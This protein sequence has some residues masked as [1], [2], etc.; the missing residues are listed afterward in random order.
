MFREFHETGT[1]TRS[2]NTIFL[3]FILKK[4]GVEDLRDF[5][6]ISLMGSLYEEDGGKGCFSRSECL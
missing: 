6:P 1:F 3:V 4:G 2:L 5:R